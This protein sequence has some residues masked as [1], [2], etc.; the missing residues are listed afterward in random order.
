PDGHTLVVVTPTSLVLNPALRRSL[1]YDPDKL[2]LVSRLYSSPL[3]VMVNP[4]VPVKTIGELIEYAKANPG[5]LN[6]GS[7][8][9]GAATHLITEHFAQV[10]GISMNHVAYKGG[11]AIAVDLLSGVLQVYFDPGAAS[12]PM[13]RDGRLRALAV[14][15]SQRSRALPEVPTVAEAGTPYE[16]LS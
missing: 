10:A 12:L 2:T 14:T 3:F 1:P 5:K 6:Y 4:Q 11:S 8:G 13:V 16:V 7:T 9:E 15:G